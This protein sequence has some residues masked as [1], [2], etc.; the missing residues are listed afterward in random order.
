MKPPSAPTSSAAASR[1]KISQTQE[2]ER[3]SA[4]LS[5]GS[6]PSSLGSFAFYDRASSSWRTSQPSLLGDLT[7]FSGTWPLSGSMRNGMCSERLT[8]ARPISVHAYSSLPTPTA[9]TSGYNRGGGMG[10]VGPIRPSLRMMARTGMWPTPTA[11]E[12]ANR[13]TKPRPSET[14]GRGHGATL[15]GAVGGQLNPTW[16]EWLMGFP[17]E[18]TACDFSAIPSSRNKRRT[19]G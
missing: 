16:V 8:S 12:N 10:R 2:R 19:P 5:P 3:E 7:E 18:H 14:D 9:S 6:G 17:I 15:A 11:S 4:G 1:A 13:T